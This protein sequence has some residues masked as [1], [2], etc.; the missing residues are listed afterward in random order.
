LQNHETRNTE[1]ATRVEPATI[2][3]PVSSSQHPAQPAPRKVSRNGKIARLPYAIRDMIN[4]MLRN[5][6]PH[7]KI[8]EALTEH[9]VTATPRNISNW[10]TRGG[11]REW[12]DQ[13]DRAV[14]TRLLQDNLVEH[15]RTT[16]A[17]QLSEVGLQLAATQLSQL[18]LK[19]NASEQLTADPEKF[20]LAVNALCRLNRQ[21]YRLQKYRDDSARELGPKHDPERLKREVE[22]DLEST[23]NTYSAEKLGQTI[24]D[25]D[26]PHRNFISKNPRAYLSLED[27]DQA[28]TRSLVD[29]L[30]ALSNFASLLKTASIKPA[31][32]SD[33][34][35]ASQQDDFSPKTAT[36]PP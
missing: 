23:R 20:S 9:G 18:F 7:S 21:L 16:D 1:H 3:N 12:C 35:S 22:K 11:Y 13:Q 26:I 34:S 31:A 5:N 28:S 30:R 29:P 2:Q 36:L 8:S 10:K 24:H 33:S 6:I 32:P 15:L 4:R 27:S 19:Q 17:T 14:E 25:Y